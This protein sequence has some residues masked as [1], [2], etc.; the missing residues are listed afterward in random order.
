MSN[1]VKTNL[2]TEIMTPLVRKNTV[3]KKKIEN[4]FNSA[5]QDYTLETMYYCETIPS[6]I[7][8]NSWQI[9][10]DFIKN[11]GLD[12]I[13]IE[14]IERIYCLRNNLKEDYIKRIAPK[15]ELPT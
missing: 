12:P 2:K 13:R 10:S 3:D 9:R 6:M 1:D 4:T 14:E 5:L 7:M 15:E 8:D 11:S